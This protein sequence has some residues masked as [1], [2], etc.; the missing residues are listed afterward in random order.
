MVNPGHRLI[1]ARS[2]RIETGSIVVSRGGDIHQVANLESPGVDLISL[3]VYSPRLQ[4]AR[5]YR[6]DGDR[7][8]F[9]FACRHC[10]SRD[11]RG[12]ASWLKGGES[13]STRSPVRR[14]IRTWIQN[15]PGGRT[16]HGRDYRLWL[17]RCDGCGSPGPP[18]PR[19]PR[20]L[21]FERGNRL[22]RGAAYGTTRPEHLLNV[23]ASLIALP[24][25]PDHFLEWLLARPP[26]SVPEPSWPG[27]STEI[28]SKK[29]SGVR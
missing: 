21:I 12:S 9:P 4:G 22:A 8:F 19:S 29:C 17:Q 1:E 20:V 6:M 27:S 28:T 7:T 3:H 18:G 11:D 5:Y 10:G 23:P 14:L 13:C 26:Q 16:C 24:D 25:E 15:G 2:H